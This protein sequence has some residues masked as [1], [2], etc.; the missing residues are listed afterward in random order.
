MLKMQ[1]MLYDSVMKIVKIEST[2]KK[3][4]ENLAVDLV[5]EEMKIPDGAFLF[6]CKIVPMGSVSKDGFQDEIQL[7]NQKSIE[8]AFGEQS[9]ELDMTPNEL[10]E[11]EKHKRRFI[12]LLIQGSSKKGHYMYLM[13]QDKLQDINPEL[14]SLY[15]KMMSINDLTYWIVPDSIIK[16][17]ASEPSNMAGKEEI[18]TTTNPP[19]ILIVA[20]TIAASERPSS[21]LFS[22]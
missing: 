20:K 9:A 15:G 12:N 18:D 16:Q 22:L 6:S 3:Y 21:R 19:T 11:L 17:M 2:Q 10:F 13:V 8:N 7:P 1:R 4:L 14:S 5:V